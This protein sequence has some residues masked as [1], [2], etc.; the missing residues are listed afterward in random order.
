VD[1]LWKVLIGC[2]G[3]E[4]VALRRPSDTPDC[5]EFFPS[6]FVGVDMV[7]LPSLL[8]DV[9]DEPEF[10]AT[11]DTV[12]R[13]FNVSIGGSSSSL[14]SGLLGHRFEGVHFIDLDGT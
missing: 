3:V 9:D 4:E 2:D 7:S 11:T 13:S 10:V 1:W 6:P 12:G 8:R 14:A 5:S